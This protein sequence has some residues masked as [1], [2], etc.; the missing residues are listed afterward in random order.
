MLQVKY[1]YIPTSVEETKKLG[2]DQLDVILFTG[3]AY[4]DH[5]AFGIAIVARILEKEGLKVAVVPQPNWRD[6]LRD[7]K[8]LGAPRLFFGVTSGNMDSMVNHYTA[9][10]RR[11]S[12]DAYTPGGK[13]GQRPDYAVTVYCQILKKLYPHIPIVIGGIEASLRRFTHYD[14]WS[15]TIKPSILIESQADLLIYGMAEKPLKELIHLLRQGFA[16]NQITTLRQSAFLLPAGSKLPELEKVNTTF[17]HS[18]EQCLK[19]KKAFAENFKIIETQSNQYHS[20]RLIE[21]YSDQWIVVNPPYQEF[22][23]EEIDEPYD[24]PYTRLPHPRYAKKPPIPAFSMIQNSITIHRGCFGACSFC[25]I[26][27]HQGRFIR[28]RSA[29]SILNEVNRVTQMPYFKGVLTDLGGPSA[30]MYQMKGK[31]EDICKKCKKQSCIFPSV[32][33]NLDTNHQPLLYLY[34]QVRSLPSIKHV[35]IGSGIRYDLFYNPHQSDI[36]K[37]TSI[38]YIQQLI[39]HHISGRLKV[40]PEHSNSNVLRLMRKPSF[41]MFKVF[42]KDFEKYCRLYQKPYQ[43][44]PYFISSHPGTTLTE[45]AQLAIETKNLHFRLEQVQDFTPTPLTLSTC[46]YYTGFDPYTGEKVYSAKTIDEKKQQQLFFFWYKP[47]NKKQIKNILTKINQL[48]LAQQLL[49]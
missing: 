44:V 12:D 30:N 11:R 17:L 14:Y 47:E 26:S 23:Q 9:N 43:L 46:M 39:Q 13:S 8:K 37:Q 6:D 31:N 2:W 1:P 42:Q 32:C 34:L 36:D 21:P 10:K 5:P 7:F 18:Y 27:A 16:V 28:S 15:D 3:D 49:K 25:T 45:M 41:D 48:Q 24:L 22:T 40:A 4:I 29:R 20:D 33:K 35:F 19:S 38:N